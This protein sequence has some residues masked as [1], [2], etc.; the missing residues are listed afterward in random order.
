MNDPLILTVAALALVVGTTLQRISG[1]GVGLVVAPIFAVLV[2]PTTGVF[3]TNCVTC[4]SATCVLLAVH[5]RIEWRRAARLLAWA[6][7]GCLLGGFLVSCLHPGVLNLIIGGIVL[8]AIVT[9]V[10]FRTLPEVGGPRALGTTGVVAGL[11]NTTAGVAAPALVI[12]A[13]LSRWEHARFAATLQPVFLGLALM[14]LTV[15]SCLG[16]GGEVL[17][18]LPPWVAV[19]MP[20]LVLTGLLIG[21]RLARWV[22][23][24]RAQRVA[25]ALAALGGAAAVA[26]G[27]MML[28][29]GG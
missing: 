28:V 11:F 8:V 12:F 27:L 26:R 3:T 19:A 16:I 22:A 1:A 18:H 13:R 10:S 14:S 15:K 2:G 23:G 5:R 6:V 25:L 21:T 7:P 24:E 4:V 20:V 29:T 17:A 9:T